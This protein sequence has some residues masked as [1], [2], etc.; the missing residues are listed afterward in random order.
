MPTFANIYRFY[1]S[2][3]DKFFYLYNMFRSG[4][5]T[6]A[7][8]RRLF[9]LDIKITNNKNLNSYTTCSSSDFIYILLFYV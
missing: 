3:F 8:K 7:L 4:L 1:L 5:V 6:A 2:S 9:S